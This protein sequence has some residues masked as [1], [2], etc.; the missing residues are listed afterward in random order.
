MTKNWTPDP[1]TAE[2]FATYAA[3]VRTERDLKPNVRER[4]E[5]ALKAG[6]TGTQLSRLTGMTPEV[7]RRMA[8]DL[9]LPID[10]RY[11]ERAEA[12][13]RRPKPETVEQAAPEPNERPSPAPAPGERP[14][15]PLDEL[16]LDPRVR[17]LTPEQARRMAGLAESEHFSWLRDVRKRLSKISPDLLPYAVANAALLAEKVQLPEA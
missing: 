5:A 4:A 11:R 17:D 3:A 16:G 9:E 7:F 10:P 13:R 6:A 15:S 2:I 14:R 12:S 8:R 1:E